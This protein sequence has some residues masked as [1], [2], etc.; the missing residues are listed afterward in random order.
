MPAAVTRHNCVS[1][2][3][4]AVGRGLLA[5]EEKYNPTPASIDPPWGLN[6]MYY[7][8]DAFATEAEAP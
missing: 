1:L 8:P 2:I 7:R 6:A 4:H 5:L 3:L